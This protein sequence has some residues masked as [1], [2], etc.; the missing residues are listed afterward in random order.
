MRKNQ[1][2]EKLLGGYTQTM[3]ES[4]NIIAKGDGGG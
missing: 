1:K 4:M 2:P 3:L